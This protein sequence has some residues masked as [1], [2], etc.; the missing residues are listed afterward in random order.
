MNLVANAIRRI[1]DDG[2]RQRK[3]R[4]QKVEPLLVSAATNEIAVDHFGA[5]SPQNARK[6]TAARAWLPDHTWQPLNL[7]QLLDR[8]L[9]GFVKIMS[10]SFIGGAPA[11][12][13]FGNGRHSTPQTQQ[14]ATVW[15]TTYSE[16]ESNR[17]TPYTA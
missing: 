15:P 12:Q 7:T 1:G 17:L 10:F 9:R 14:T 3:L 4:F 5:V 11:S 16:I 8:P 13:D 2:G 6:L